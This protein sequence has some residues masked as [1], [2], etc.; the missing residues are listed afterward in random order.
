MET[1]DSGTYN[2]GWYQYATTITVQSETINGS[3]IHG[4]DHGWSLYQ[5]LTVTI[6][7]NNYSGDESGWSHTTDTIQVL[8]WQQKGASIV[9]GQPQWYGNDGASMSTNASETTADANGTVIDGWND[10]TFASVD[11]GTLYLPDLAFV[12]SGMEEITAAVGKFAHDKGILGGEL[13]DV[14]RQETLSPVPQQELNGDI[15][16]ALAA[17]SPNTMLGAAAYLQ[18]FTDKTFGGNLSFDQGLKG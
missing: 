9:G 18:D 7:H 4:R 3:W 1:M 15:A 10:S 12:S 13:R 11:P 17:F 8:A 2:G 6:E 14:A 16:G 5:G